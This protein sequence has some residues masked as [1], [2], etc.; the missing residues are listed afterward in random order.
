MR[1]RCFSNVIEKF[2][3]GTG[4][5]ELVTKENVRYDAIVA[6]SN[7]N[8]LALADHNKELVHWNLSTK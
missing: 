1:V 8:T 4:L 6:N 2:E 5:S 7:G 3:L